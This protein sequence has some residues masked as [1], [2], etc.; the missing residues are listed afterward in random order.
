LLHYVAELRGD[1]KYPPLYEIL[2]IGCACG[3]GTEVLAETFPHAAVDGAD[4]NPEAIKE[5]EARHWPSVRRFYPNTLEWFRAGTYDLIVASHVL[6]H[7][8]NPLEF[9]QQARR[10]A[11]GEVLVYAPWEER[12]FQIT[13]HVCVIDDALLSEIPCVIRKV[14][15]PQSAGGWAAPVV[16]F[17]CMGEGRR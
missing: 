8:E 2:D 14:V 5:A 6:E 12:P 13:G 9:M 11:R 15:R 4:I 17:A 1:D 16:I 10:V 7:Q 3:A